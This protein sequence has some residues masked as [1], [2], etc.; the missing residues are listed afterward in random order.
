MAA[1]ITAHAMINPMLECSVCC[2]VFKDPRIL[3]CGHTFCLKCLQGI[4]KTAVG[5]FN[6]NRTS[7]KIDT[8]PCPQCRTPFVVGCQ[9]LQDLPKNFTVADLI[10]SLP[11][12]S[13]CVLL[14]NGDQHGPAQ[15]V[16][17][18]CWDA[19]CD[20]CSKVHTKTKLTQDHLVK[21]LTEVSTADIQA[22]KAKQPV[23]CE[24]HSQ[25][26]VKLSCETFQRFACST[27]NEVKCKQ[28][29]CLELSD[30]DDKFFAKL[31]KTS[32][33]LQSIS[34]KFDCTT[35]AI[36]LAIKQLSNNFGM[37]QNDIDTLLSDAEK[38]LQK[39]YEKLLTIIKQCRTTAKR[40]VS[41][42]HNN[43]KE[44][45]NASLVDKRER[46]HNLKQH[47][48]SVEHHL[49]PSATACDRSKFIIDKLPDIEKEISCQDKTEV[50]TYLQ[51]DISK[52]KTDM[53]AWLEYIRAALTTATARLPLL[54]E[55]FLET[56]RYI[57]YNI[58][59]C[60]IVY[61]IKQAMC[62][63]SLLFKTFVLNNDYYI[64]K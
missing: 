25:K 45:L 32:Q 26:A 22:H 50:I 21:L 15:H 47:M 20:T 31:N 28:H 33:L 41:K 13:Q 19:L 38:K 2:E 61:S 60:E 8:K 14:G 62:E 16:C 40:T 27:C 53:T 43:Q 63:H 29:N 39:T 55:Q 49:A 5:R 12:N 30:A 24:A 11:A 59:C 64:H 7:A 9:N 4:V 57:V 58:S 6:T 34:Y 37:V 42:L 46:M 10:C 54:A 23:Y 56:H 18:D 3:P 52:W 17:V 44:Q 35:R 48:A 1:V 51:P 36:S